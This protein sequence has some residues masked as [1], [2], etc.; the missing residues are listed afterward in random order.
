MSQ[1]GLQ[2]VVGRLLINAAF[3]QRFEQQAAKCLSELAREGIVLTNAEVAALT[4]I[5]PDMWTM[6]ADQLTAHMP[7]STADSRDRPSRPLTPRERQVLRAV[8]DGLTNK[9]IASQ[10]G[11]SESAVKATVQQLFRKSR[12][13]SRTQLVRLTL[14]RVEHHEGRVQ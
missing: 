11:V 5:H 8:C 13:H 4:G 2:L 9:Q 7:S 3:R 1:M 6:L 10:L 14:H 12:V